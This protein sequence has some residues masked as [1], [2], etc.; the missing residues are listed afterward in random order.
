MQNLVSCTSRVSHP[1]SVSRCPVGLTLGARRLCVVHHDATPSRRSAI[2]EWITFSGEAE[3]A[4]STEGEKAV[5]RKAS[6]GC[7][8]VQHSL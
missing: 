8:A 4:R 7:V 3:K 5:P 6:G 2:R 1:T